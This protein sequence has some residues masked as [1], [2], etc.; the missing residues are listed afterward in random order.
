MQEWRE[1]LVSVL[2]L[3]NVFEF[4]NVEGDC[5]DA[6]FEQGQADLHVFDHLAGD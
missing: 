6:G 5:A 2:H 3:A 4:L 1:D